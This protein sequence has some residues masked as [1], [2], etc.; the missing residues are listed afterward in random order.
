MRNWD[1]YR[2][3]L[4]VAR[5]GSLTAASSILK[6]DPATV[7]RRVQRLEHSLGVGL[8]TKMP[9]GYV[10]TS[11][12]QDLQKHIEQIESH[13]RIA[14]GVVQDTDETLTGTVRIGATDGLSNFVLPQVCT[15]ITKTYP[16]LNIQILTLPP[17]FNLTKREADMAIMVTPPKMG[18]LLSEKIT[19]Y[20]LHLAAHRDYLKTHGAITDVKELKNHHTVGYIPD[21][22]FDP[23]V[24]YHSEIFPERTP[25]LSSNSVA[26]QMQLVRQG[27][28][29]SVIH[30]FVLPYFK[31]FE[32][33]LVDEISLTRS[34]YM[35]RL[36]D[37]Q[38]NDRLN[39]IAALLMDGVKSEVAQLESLIL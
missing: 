33:F 2:V 17:V 18:R 11:A 21:L 30:D 19:D 14:R 4:E 34:F 15:A 31:D 38:T 7:G 6:M 9:R 23:S 25:N 37:D 1:D 26:V 12:G 3:F 29:I 36:R 32:R 24:D 16:A 27:G 35:V 13:E 39:R 20:H 28:G 5:T 8:F 10:L 22:V